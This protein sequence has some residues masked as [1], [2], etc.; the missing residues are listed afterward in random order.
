M[1]W[2]RGGAAVGGTPAQLGLWNTYNRVGV[3][4]YVLDTTVSYTYNS[5]TVR[6]ARGQ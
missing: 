3:K 4:G 6:P 2:Q 5:S 1:N